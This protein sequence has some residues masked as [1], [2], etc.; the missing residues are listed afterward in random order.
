MKFKLLLGVMF[1]LFPSGFKVFILRLR[2][3]KIGKGVKIG[4]SIFVVSDKISIGDGVRISHGNLFLNDGI[5]LGKGAKIGYLNTFKGPFQLVLKEK[6]QV[7]NKNYC[8]RAGKGISY[9]RSKLEIGYN[10]KITVKCHIDLT[11]DVT[12]G[13][14]SILAGI[15]TQV[16]THGYYHA[17]EGEDRIRIDGT[18]TIKSNVYVGSSCIFNPGVTVEKGI[19]IGGGSVISKDLT[20][21]GMYVNQG[22]RHI[23]TSFNQTK[24]KLNEIQAKGLR[25]RVFE[26]R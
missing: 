9:G 20:E 23:K 6:G 7:G 16:W 14:N 10:A 25:E 13:D 26:K 19:H 17:E 22:L 12:V 3:H 5:K 24:E 1:A 11:R 21:R 8:T 4:M 15:A 18:V 2:G